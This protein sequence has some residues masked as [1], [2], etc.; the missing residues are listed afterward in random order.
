MIFGASQDV[1]GI[2]Q[3]RPQRTVQN[4]MMKAWATFADD[5]ADGLEKNMK[6]P[7][8]DPNGR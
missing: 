4:M 3:S 2:P 5:P 6:W 1:S 8:Y 7:K